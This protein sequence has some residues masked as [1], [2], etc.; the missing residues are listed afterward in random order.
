[1][2][3]AWHSLIE[4]GQLQKIYNKKRKFQENK[5]EYSNQNE[6][7]FIGLCYLFINQHTKKMR[8]EDK[9]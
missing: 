7:I 3:S 8:E 9:I 6:N 1:L 5:E 4:K 2:N